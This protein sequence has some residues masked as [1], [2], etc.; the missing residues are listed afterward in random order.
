MQTTRVIQLQKQDGS[1]SN[2]TILILEGRAKRGCRTEIV[3]SICDAYIRET[4]SLFK[5]SA[6]VHTLLPAL[7]MEVSGSDIR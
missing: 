3:R 4:Q 7:G 2:V 1:T 5:T 6:H